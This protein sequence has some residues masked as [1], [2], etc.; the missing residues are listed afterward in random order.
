[1]LIYVDFECISNLSFA[2]PPLTRVHRRM[3]KRCIVKTIELWMLPSIFTRNRAAGTIQQRLCDSSHAFQP[4][5]INKK[6]YDRGTCIKCGTLSH[7]SS[8]I[9]RTCNLWNVLPSSC[10]PES[11]NL[12]SFKSKINKLDLISLSS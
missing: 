1:M 12:P 10:F 8:F 7:K 3:R 5:T 4:F 6:K 9:P 11:Y 2:P